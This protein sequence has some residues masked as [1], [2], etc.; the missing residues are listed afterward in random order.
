MKQRLLW[1]AA[2]AVVALVAAGCGKVK[3]TEAQDGAVA[4]RAEEA[5]EREALAQGGR[6]KVPS[7]NVV[8]LMANGKDEYNKRLKEQ[9]S[10]QVGK[11]QLGWTPQP[12]DGKGDAKKL[13][14]CGIGAIDGGSVDFIFSSGIPPKDMSRILKKAYYKEVPVINIR[15]SVPD[16]K[17][18]AASYVP[19]EKAMAKK[20]DDYMIKKLDQI[21]PEQRKILVLTS[22]TGGGADRVAQLKEDIKGHDIKIVEEVETDLEKAKNSKKTVTKRLEKHDDIKAVWLAHESSVEPAGKAV[23]KAFKG[24]EFPDRPL[25]LGFE[26]DPKAAEAIRDDEADA[27]VDVA[28]DATLWIAA[29]QAAEMLGR[30]RPLPEGP[31]PEYPL[32]FLDIALVT[33]DNVP[34]KKK[35]REPKEDFITFFRAKW[36]DEFGPPPKPAG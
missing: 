18:L 33:K 21:P 22:S 32:D 19:D 9:L 25:V 30:Q 27:V 15:A 3:G 2:L 4:H 16:N 10:K 8:L 6:T 17:L 24:E 28:Y 13:E 7:A 31:K 29:D 20:L 26:A 14:Q 34:K 23:D 36:R 5:G 35:F 12:C 11:D 1:L